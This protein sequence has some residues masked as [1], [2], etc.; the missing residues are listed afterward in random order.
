MKNKGMWKEKMTSF[1]RIGHPLW[2]ITTRI[3]PIPFNIS[4]AVS[5]SIVIWFGRLN[6]DAVK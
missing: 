3:I 2:P 5:L 4:M 1:N 6:V